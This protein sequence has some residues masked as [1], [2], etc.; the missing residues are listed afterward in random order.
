MR[1]SGAVPADYEIRV[2]AASEA[3]AGTGGETQEQPGAYTR[4]ACGTGHAFAS[5]AMP[6]RPMLPHPAFDRDTI[7]RRMGVAREDACG[8]LRSAA[9]RR[10]GRRDT[11]VRFQWFVDKDF[12][13]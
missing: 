8:P 11:P 4:F 1:S 2:F 12:C 5:A 7:H 3:A 13:Q 9:T 6:P 10:C